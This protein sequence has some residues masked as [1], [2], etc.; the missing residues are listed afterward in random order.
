MLQS[1]QIN[2]DIKKALMV[3]FCVTTTNGNGNENEIE[4]D[5]IEE[6]I[7][8][9][10]YIDNFDQSEDKR[11][12][13]QDDYAEESDIGM[14]NE[15]QM[16]EDSHNSDGDDPESLEKLLEDAYEMDKV[17]KE[18]VNAKKSGLWKLPQALVKK[19]IALSMGDLKIENK[20][21]YIKNR[22]YVPDNKKLQLYL[23]QQHHDPPIQG[24]PG[25]KAM[26]QK[27]QAN[28]F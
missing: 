13:G 7:D 4:P 23:L 6:I 28:Y 27:I 25:Y 19:G 11:P 21:L 20:R 22:M 18:I 8:V 14:S 3:A 16:H 9:N 15:P 26:Y 1:H 5:Q 10:N 12:I 2:E 24:H 17:V